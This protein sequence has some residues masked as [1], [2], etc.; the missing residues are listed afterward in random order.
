[1]TC[2]SMGRVVSQRRTKE[3]WTLL[4]EMHRAIYPGTDTVFRRTAGQRRDTAAQPGGAPADTRHPMD[5]AIEHLSSAFPLTTTEWAAWSATM[6]PPQLQGR[7]ALAGY[8]AGR[9]PVFGQVTV[10]S[11][12][13]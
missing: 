13:E 12:G 1:M 5:R 3:E 11:Q 10:T 4:L 6:R 2:H 7:W 8:Q 9:G